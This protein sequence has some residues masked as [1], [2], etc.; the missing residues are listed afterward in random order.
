MPACPDKTRRWRP[1]QLNLSRKVTVTAA[2]E[3]LVIAQDSN[4]LMPGHV[5]WEVSIIFARL[6]DEGALPFEVSGRSVLELGAGCGVAGM[7]CALHGASV[8]LTDLPALVP[9]LEANVEQNLGPRLTPYDWTVMPFDW[10]EEPPPQLRVRR[11]DVVL[12]TDCVYHA[13]LVEPLVRALRSVCTPTTTLCLVYE[14][15]DAQVLATFEG[16]I[17][18]AFK[19]RRPLSVSRLRDVLGDE[20]LSRYDESSG[21]NS[22]PDTGWLTIAI[23]RRKK[24]DFVAFE[25]CFS[26][27]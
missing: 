20:I 11:F 15:R 17:K 6:L 22:L 19:V 27:R 2:N 14:R 23:C 18:R 12:A 13:H 16:M 9:H 4:S 5:L 3:E 1:G 10:T 7:A 8:A 24:A 21:D 26:D 25:S